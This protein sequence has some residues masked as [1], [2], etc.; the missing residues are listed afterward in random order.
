LSLVEVGDG[1]EEVATGF[2]QFVLG[3]QILQHG[4]DAGI[5]PRTREPR[6]FIGGLQRLAREIDL[7]GERAQPRPLLHHLPAHGITSFLQIQL[8]LAG[9]RGTLA[10]TVA[11]EQAA[12]TDAPAQ[13][14]RAAASSSSG[15]TANACEMIAATSSVA[16]ASGGGARSRF[17]GCQLDGRIEVEQLRH[18]G[19]RD[20]LL[21]PQPA[22]PERCRGARKNG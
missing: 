22:K 3:L 7:L 2:R 14:V 6:G 9:A 13:A 4:A 10:L 8:A 21:G 16:L 18:A 12:R 15:R 17:G 1:R 5:A 20:P 11:I 19:R